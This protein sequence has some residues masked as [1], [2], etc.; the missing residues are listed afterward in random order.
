MTL[1]QDRSHFADIRTL[2]LNICLKPKQ[3]RRKTTL[4][5]HELLKPLRLVQKQDAIE[6]Y[7]RTNLRAQCT[8]ITL[9]WTHA[10]LVNRQQRAQICARIVQ[11][12][13]LLTHT[14][15]NTRALLLVWLLT[16]SRS[17]AVVS[18]S[19]VSLETGISKA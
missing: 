3:K 7:M 4:H 1:V 13:T 10:L 15:P 18:K 11:T 6:A 19:T 8:V 9:G 14:C 5:L 12:I 16:S 17:L 2:Q